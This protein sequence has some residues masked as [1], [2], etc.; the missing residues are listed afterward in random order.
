M[1]HDFESVRRVI[2][3]GRKDKCGDPYSGGAAVPVRSIAHHQRFRRRDAELLERSFEEPRTR[4]LRSVLERQ[5]VAIY[6]LPEAM[7][8]EMWRQLVVDVAYD[9]DPHAAS[10]Q[11]FQ[12]RGGIWIRH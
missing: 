11:P 9:A 8:I 4:L 12:N 6:E 10:L 1:Q 5:R 7:M 2:R 3:D